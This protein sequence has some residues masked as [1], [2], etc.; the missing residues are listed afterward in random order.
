MGSETSEAVGLVPLSVDVRGCG[1]VAGAAGGA[2][3]SS[4]GSSLPLFPMDMNPSSPVLCL[5]SGDGV[6]QASSGTPGPSIP[7]PVPV[8][9]DSQEG[10]MGGPRRLLVQ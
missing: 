4:Q 8:S 1:D 2:P 5:P 7:N 10:G 9:W 6:S 3:L